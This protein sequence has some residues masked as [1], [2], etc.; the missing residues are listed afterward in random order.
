MFC[1]YNLSMRKESPL[2]AWSR[3]VKERD[4]KCVRCGR[5][6]DL[7]AH[8]IQPKATHPELRLDLENGETL[9]YRCH[10]KVHDE[11]RIRVRGRPQ[12]KTLEK[13]I[14][15]LRE[16]VRALKAANRK[17]NSRVSECDRG[18]CKA[19]IALMRKRPMSQSK[20]GRRGAAQ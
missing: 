5:T 12:R 7:H 18:C 10:K 2:Q 8:H 3:M 16:E 20:T 1:P 17:L 13:M 15:M 11:L 4:G 19:V 14:E 9:C 6:D